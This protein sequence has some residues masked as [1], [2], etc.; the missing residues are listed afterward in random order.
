LE[1]FFCIY[2]ILTKVLADQGLRMK[3]MDFGFGACYEYWFSYLCVEWEK[4]MNGVC[5][6]DDG[7]CVAMVEAESKEGLLNE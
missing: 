6:V 2:I 7:E 3:S 4:Y 1:G 5:L